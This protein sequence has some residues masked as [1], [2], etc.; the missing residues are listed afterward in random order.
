MNGD[1]ESSYKQ[2]LAKN[3]DPTVLGNAEAVVHWDMET[4]MP[5]KAIEQR[6]EQLALL[7]RLHHKLAIDPEIGALLNTIQTSPNYDSM[8]QIEKRNI[9][10]IAKTYRE[11]I[12]LPER[13]VGDLAMQEAVTV[14]NW[15][16]AKA[17]RDFNL[18]KADLQKLFDLSLEAAEILMKAKGTKTPYESLIDNFEP[19]MS[20][21]AITATFTELLGGLKPLITKI[22]DCQTQPDAALLSTPVPVEEQRRISQLITLTLGYDTASPA[23]CGRVDETE[24][25]F[26]TGCYNDVR[27]TTHYYPNNFA[28]SLFSVLHE[29]GHAIYEHN[30]NQ[31]WMYQPVGATCSYGIHESQSRFYE[32]I[33]GRS[34]EFWMG[35][36]PQV[37]T[38]APS[39]GGLPLDDFIRAINRVERS[40]IRIEADEVT[41]SIHII[42]RFE[43]ERDLFAGKIKIDELPG[44]WNQKYQDYLGV[45]VQN[46]SEGV[47]QDTHWA[48]GLFGYFPSYA[49]GNIYDGQL[50]DSIS[51]DVPDWKSQLSV[52]NLNAVNEWLK[53]SIHNKGN[54]YNP[55]ELIRLVTGSR[56]NSA[57]FIRY[58]SIK[59]GDLYGF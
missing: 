22:E 10:L 48:S 47:M 54:R 38:V 32:N 23:A 18:Y 52:G 9:H 50:Y 49:L 17:K 2:L 43:L 55:E 34:R 42:I 44:A 59:Y 16:K 11:Q 33:V 46:D 27:I 24:H 30:L 37:K 35:F 28:S 1:V 56:L 7:S 53:K 19:N 12:A 40:K 45:E 51:R 21:D 57:P 41:Y 8:G 36:L 15:K 29:S 5:P 31:E 6:G 25:P 58:L 4:M 39:L 13:L 3:K 20:A 26:T 14:N